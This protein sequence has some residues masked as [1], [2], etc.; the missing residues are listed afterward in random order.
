LEGFGAL[1]LP[2]CLESGVLS[3]WPDGECSPLV[4]ARRVDTIAKTRAGTAIGDGKL[5]LDQVGMVL[6]TERGPA[7]ARFSLW[8]GRLLV[9]PIQPKLTRID[10]RC[11]PGL[12]LGVKGYGTNHLNPKASVPIDQDTSTHIPR[13]YQMLSWWESG[14]VHLLLNTFCH[15]FIGFGSLGRG[16]VR[17]QVGERLL[18]GFGEVR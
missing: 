11:G 14:L 17:D 15:R 3:L 18:T 2:C 4:F 5:D 12:P 9:V 7:A 16:D 13:I 1:L 6:P 8:A 10:A